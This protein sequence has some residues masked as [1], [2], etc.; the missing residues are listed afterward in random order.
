MNDE[1]K[2]RTTRV[3]VRNPSPPSESISDG[4]AVAAISE[5]TKIINDH[6]YIMSIKLEIEHVDQ[7]VEDYP[8][9]FTAEIPNDPQNVTELLIQQAELT[10]REKS[11]LGNSTNAVRLNQLCSV[12]SKRLRDIMNSGKKVDTAMINA[13][14]TRAVDE[15]FN[16]MIY[17]TS[18]EEFKKTINNMDI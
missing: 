7:P 10:F 16:V 2:P 3:E 14:I 9:V 12:V 5:I 15:G 1:I 17:E 11:D 18:V 13:F 8:D 6:Q 4:L